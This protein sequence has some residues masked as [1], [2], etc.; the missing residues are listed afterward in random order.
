V[1]IT[2]SINLNVGLLGGTANIQTIFDLVLRCL[3]HVRCYRSYNLPYAAFQ[4][5]K[6]VDLNLV[7][8]VLHIILQEKIQRG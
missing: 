7:N 5:L 1:Y 8:N 2:F 4:V 3:K 6:A